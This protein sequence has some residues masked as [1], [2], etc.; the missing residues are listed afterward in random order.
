MSKTNSKTTQSYELIQI[1]GDE[2]VVVHKKEALRK[3]KEKY[4]NHI[5]YSFLEIEA[6]KDLTPE[7]IEYLHFAK[8]V[9]GVAI[10]DEETAVRHN[11]I[12]KRNP[13][14]KKRPSLKI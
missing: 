9:F 5:L 14:T 7:E 10:Y 4:P 8:K 13:N 2:V 6:M 11:I 1:G 12:K 3:T